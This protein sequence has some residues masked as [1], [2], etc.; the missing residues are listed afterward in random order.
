MGS[1]R[2]AIVARDFSG[3]FDETRTIFIKYSIARA[4]KRELTRNQAD[5]LTIMLRS[6][7]YHNFESYIGEDLDRSY[8]SVFS[9]RIGIMI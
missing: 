8:L 3:E 2:E 5:I 7:K 1:E 6:D 4:Q 9:G